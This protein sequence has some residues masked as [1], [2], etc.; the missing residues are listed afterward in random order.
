MVGLRKT[1]NDMSH[2]SLFSGQDV[3]PERREYEAER[4]V[5]L[6]KCVRKGKRTELNLFLGM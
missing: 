3:N 6:L 5:L 2:Y 4:S 1:A